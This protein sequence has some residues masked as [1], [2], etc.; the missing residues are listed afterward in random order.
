MYVSKEGEKKRTI[1][2]NTVTFAKV[3]PKGSA[4]AALADRGTESKRRAADMA[5]W[6]AENQW[7][8]SGTA[9]GSAG[10]AGWGAGAPRPKNQGKN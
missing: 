5:K 7:R 9:S 6:E 10:S 2:A 1:A 4:G 3:P 8:D